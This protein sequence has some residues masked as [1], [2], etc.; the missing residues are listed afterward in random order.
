M[1]KLL[2]LLVLI[3]LAIVA[4]LSLG[5]GRGGRKDEGGEMREE[6]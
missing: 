6:G 2:D 1:K 5:V 3:G 4:A